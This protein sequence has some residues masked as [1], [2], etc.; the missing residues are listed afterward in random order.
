M[1]VSGIRPI[2][3]VKEKERVVCIDG[4]ERHCSLIRAYW[5]DTNC[6]SAGWWIEGIGCE[7]GPLNNCG[8]G[9]VG[10]HHF[11]VTC[12]VEQKRVFDFNAQYTNSFHLHKTDYKC[13]A[14]AGKVWKVGGYVQGEETPKW[15]REFY[16]DSEFTSDNKYS[17][18][19]S[20]MDGNVQYEGLCF[21]EDQRVYFIPD[22]ETVPQLLYDFNSQAGDLIALNKTDCVVEYVLDVIS[23][24]RELRCTV[25]FE[26]QTADNSS[27]PSERNVCAKN[28]WIEGVGSILSPL[29]SGSSQEG[30]IEQL[31]E[32]TVNGDTIY[33]GENNPVEE[34]NR[35]L[36]NDNQDNVSF[37][38]VYSKSSNNQYYDLSGR[39]LSAPPAKGVY[40]ENGKKVVAR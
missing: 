13:F 18:L 35:M 31:I 30:I 37:P 39:R 34:L 29:T 3:V 10:N 27:H 15:V 2:D 1:P 17:R 21:E 6:L 32:C 38:V 40:I 24:G 7:L 9:A 4:V 14:Q 22:G 25:F 5:G 26:F 36:T 12:E 16:F 23:A 33:T 20:C 19:M 11:P 28:V 8:F